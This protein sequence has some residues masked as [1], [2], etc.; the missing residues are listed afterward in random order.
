[1][2]VPPSSAVYRAL[3]ESSPTEPVSRYAAV[4]RDIVTRAAEIESHAKRVRD[5]RDDVVMS[6][7]IK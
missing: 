4:F 5:E 6:D 2:P 3:H 1:M 7:T